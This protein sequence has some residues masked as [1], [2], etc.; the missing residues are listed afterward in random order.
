MFFCPTRIKH[1]QETNKCT[2]SLQSYSDFRDDSYS[3]SPIKG[4]DNIRRPG[5]TQHFIVRTLQMVHYEAA[6]H[7]LVDSSIKAIAQNTQ[8]ISTWPREEQ[9]EQMFGP[10]EEIKVTPVPCPHWAGSLSSWVTVTVLVFFINR[11]H[12]IM[13]GSDYTTRRSQSA[14]DMA[15]TCDVPIS[16]HQSGLQ[17]H[18]Q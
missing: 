2:D 16:Q 7:S 6:H 8:R 5:A 10:E 15:D 17:E 14:R 12:V 11:Q 13:L 1:K 3:G 9:R 18:V 4:Q